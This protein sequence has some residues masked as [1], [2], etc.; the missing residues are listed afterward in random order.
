MLLHVKGIET[1]GSYK[2]AKELN[3]ETMTVEDFKQKYIK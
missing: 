2:K 3:I 1:S